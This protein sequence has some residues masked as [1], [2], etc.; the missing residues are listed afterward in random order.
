[1][2]EATMY[3]TG[4][5]FLSLRLISCHGKVLKSME[6]KAIDI[7]R[8]TDGTTDGIEQGRNITQREVKAIK[9][10]FEQQRYHKKG[11]KHIPNKIPILEGRKRCFCPFSASCPDGFVRTY[12]QWPC[13]ANPIASNSVPAP[14]YSF[15]YGW[16]WLRG[17]FGG[18]EAGSQ[19]D[20]S[21]CGQFGWYCK[22][23]VLLAEYLAL[24][25]QLS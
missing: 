22:F 9:S 20:S 3:F 5:L 11:N 25:N 13:M 17:S 7:L 4:L 21:A 18:D 23:F 19:L 16:P 24:E 1:M 15:G 2:T 8:T 14:L 12:P 6:N 10:R